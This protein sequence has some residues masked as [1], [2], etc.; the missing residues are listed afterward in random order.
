MDDIIAHI[1]KF[2]EERNLNVFSAKTEHTMLSEEL[3]EFLQAS[4]SNDEHD[5]VN[6][7]CDIIVLAVGGLN[8]LA[9][10]TAEVLRETVKEILSRK[11][12][13]NETTGK[14][15]KDKNQNPDSLYKPNYSTAKIK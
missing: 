6:A 3:E 5:Q 13:I 15:E 4:L 9:Y 12:S 8:K 10:D 1:L 14:W 11:G 2:N 7:L